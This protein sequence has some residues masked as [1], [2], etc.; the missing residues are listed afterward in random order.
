M[1]LIAS[2]LQSRPPRPPRTDFAPQ[3]VCVNWSSAWRQHL[4]YADGLY[5]H[6]FFLLSNKYFSVSLSFSFSRMEHVSCCC[7]RFVDLS[8]RQPLQHTTHERC[9]VYI[10]IYVFIV[11]YWS[12]SLR[13][14]YNDW[15]ACV[16]I[17]NDIYIGSLWFS[18]AVW[19]VDA[20]IN[21]HAACTRLSA[22]ISNAAHG[23]VLTVVYSVFRPRCC[24][25]FRPPCCW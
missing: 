22:I 9:C 13:G 1:Y 6:F 4:M 20:V 19:W 25:Q 15:R 17:W 2:P 3:R 21:R 11:S 12:F 24:C 18:T 5:I 14:E 10:F 23:N 7:T 8:A 16:Y